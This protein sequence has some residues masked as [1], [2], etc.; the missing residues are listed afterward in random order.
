MQN[1][2][3]RLIASSVLALVATAALAQYPSRAVRVIVPYPP[4]ASADVITRSVS[5][6]L[7]EA[8]GQPFVVENRIGA[9]GNIG[10][11][12]LA[13]SPP[14]G[15]TIGLGIASNVAANMHLYRNLPYDSEKDLS[16]I[17]LVASVP[18][19]LVASMALPLT[20]AKSLAALAKAKSGSLSYASGGVGSLAHLSAEML[21]IHAGVDAVHVPFKSASDIILSLLSNNV[22]FGF[23]VFSTAFPHVKAGKLRALA[24]TGTKRHPLLPDVPTM[25]EAFPPGFDLDTWYAFFAPAGTPREAITRLHA[26]ILKIMQDPAFVARF[27]SDGTEVRVSSSPEELGA[28]VRTEIVKWGNVIKASGAR[29]D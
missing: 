13:K 21:R 29:L 5:Q 24:V 18:A 16:P 28:Y 1:L 14:D 6:R 22:A 8:L 23:P 25:R 11:G 26:E 10:L 2:I 3:A 7:S 12:L 17:S 9:G 20:D 15:Y 4:G 27:T 19:V